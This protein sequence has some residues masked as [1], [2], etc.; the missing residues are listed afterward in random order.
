MFNFRA[1]FGYEGQT[2]DLKV[3]SSGS[4]GI[5]EMVDELS[6][7]K[8]MYAFLKLRDTKT[9][10]DKYVLI[11]W[12]GEGA[13]T[14]RKGICANHLRDIE[15]FLIGT[16]VTI[17]ARNED[18]V[19]P[20]LIMDKVAK[21]SSTS[22][23]FKSHKPFN[24]KIEPVGTSYQRV[25]PAKEIM[26]SERDE[27]WKKEKEEQTRLEEERKRL[28]MQKQD[29]IR[30]M[31]PNGEG[32]VRQEKRQIEQVVKKT[33]EKPIRASLAKQ[34]LQIDDINENNKFTEESDDDSSQFS[35]IKRSPKDLDK[36]T[37]SPL[38]ANSF[39]I[40]EK[41]MEQMTEQQFVDEY[42]YGLAT[43]LKARALYD[44]QAGMRKS[45]LGYGL[46]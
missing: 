18:E 13:H 23:N 32:N 22:Y 17:N 21:A 35:T 8:V 37:V 9:S 16:H 29:E 46:F 40:A 15:T 14:V 41:A 3:V 4:D 10:L 33:P 12:Q 38:E 11:N 42:I 39:P 25:N 31:K 2:N 7:G 43:D 19:E 24:E 27:F 34:Q 44:Y 6:S 1:L 30:L 28:Q 45:L 26:S 36:K 20:S 5:E